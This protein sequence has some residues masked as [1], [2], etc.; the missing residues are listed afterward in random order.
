MDCLPHPV[1]MFPGCFHSVAYY[2]GC[3]DV[4]L[5]MASLS[6]GTSERCEAKPPWRCLWKTFSCVYTKVSQLFSFY[7]SRRSASPVSSTFATVVSLR[8]PPLPLIG[9]ISGSNSI[10]CQSSW[11][12]SFQ[13]FYHLNLFL[14]CLQEDGG[15]APLPLLWFYQSREDHVFHTVSQCSLPEWYKSAVHTALINGMGGQLSIPVPSCILLVSPWNSRL[16]QSITD[17]SQVKLGW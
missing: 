9:S 14:H 1:H 16:Q 17:N 4:I 8:A 15:R 12:D 3:L 5:S 13:C 6:T 2:S 7:G 11:L 10:D